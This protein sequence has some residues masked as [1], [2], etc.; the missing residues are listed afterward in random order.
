MKKKEKMAGQFHDEKVIT[1]VYITGL[2][3]MRADKYAVKAGMKKGEL[4]EKAL[5]EY[6][7]N[8]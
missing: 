6:M 7:K 4:M 2:T 1:T 3:K 5:I 8:H